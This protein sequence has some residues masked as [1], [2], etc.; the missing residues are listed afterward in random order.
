MYIVHWLV[1]YETR[2]IIHTLDSDESKRTTTIMKKIYKAESVARDMSKPNDCKLHFEIGFNPPM[3]AFSIH[4]FEDFWTEHLKTLEMYKKKCE[5]LHCS[6][7]SNFSDFNFFCQSK[8]VTYQP[9]NIST[10]GANETTK[11]QSVF[12]TSQDISTSSLYFRHFQ[13]DYLNMP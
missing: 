8:F 13:D 5:V 4:I 1:G 6:K 11:F 9:L 7:V 2:I 12:F 10:P 3:H